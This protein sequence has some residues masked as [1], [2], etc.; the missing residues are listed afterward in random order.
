MKPKLLPLNTLT[1]L[2][3]IDAVPTLLKVIL[4]EG[5]GPLSMQISYLSEPR[6]K[7]LYY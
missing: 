3:V 6:G 7:D 2:E 5:K 4:D 1:E